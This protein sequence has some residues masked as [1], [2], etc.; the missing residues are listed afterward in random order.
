MYREECVGRP[1]MVFASYCGSLRTLSLHTTTHCGLCVG[2]RS[3]RSRVS[4]ACHVCVP[5]P[6]SPLTH[7]GRWSRL[8]VARRSEPRQV[9]TADAARLGSPRHAAA[10]CGTWSR[11]AAARGHG[12]PRL[13]AA[14]RGS[15]RSVTCRKTSM[16]YVTI[17]QMRLCRREARRVVR[18]DADRLAGAGEAAGAWGACR[19]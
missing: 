9:V 13:A 3:R 10:R 7:C 4:H 11:H 12:S 2:P 17:R 6:R 18:L 15:P 8:A 16:H 1:R 5:R 14:R 19:S